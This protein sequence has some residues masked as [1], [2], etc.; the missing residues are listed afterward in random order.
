MPEIV[1]TA[2]I[3]NSGTRNEV[4]MRVV[5]LFSK[6]MA[7]EGRGELASRYK[8]YVERLSDGRRIFLSRPAFMHNGFDFVV[9]VE[10][11]NFTREGRRRDTPSHEDMFLDL[12]E[13]K[14]QSLDGYKRLY[15]LLRQVY[16]CQ[17]VSDDIMRGVQIN[18]GMP[19]EMILK[20]FKW[21]F[22]E[23]EIRYWNY[24]GRDMLWQG[25][26]SI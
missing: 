5:D 6:E 7:G 24:S 4:R 14:E 1:I 9:R 18:V 3:S 22:I 11:M 2:S 8:Y 25:V 26:P 19:A 23:Q 21:L 20:V 12:Q 13:K 17:D 16:T 10:G 15:A